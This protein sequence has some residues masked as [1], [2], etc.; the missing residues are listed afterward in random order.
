MLGVH[1]EQN[2]E[3]PQEQE[4]KQQMILTIKYIYMV[5]EKLKRT[6]EKRKGGA[7]PGRETA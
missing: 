3:S 1:D 4:L 5:G 7:R 6:M 2:K